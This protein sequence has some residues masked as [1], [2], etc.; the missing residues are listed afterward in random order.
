MPPEATA[1]EPAE[2]T[3]FSAEEAAAFIEGF[4]GMMLV[5]TGG[6]WAVAVPVRVSYDGDL[7]AGQVFRPQPLAACRD[8]A[9]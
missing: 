1:V 4:N 7:V 2:P 3:C 6:L 8:A 9:G 5:E